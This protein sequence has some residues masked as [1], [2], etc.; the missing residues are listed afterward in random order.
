MKYIVSLI[1]ILLI[2]ACSSH[3]N[4][5]SSS[6]AEKITITKNPCYGY[7][8]EYTFVIQNNKTVL[9]N[10]RGNMKN[11]LK[12]SYSA[13]ITKDKL[14]AIKALDFTSMKDSYGDHGISDLSS[15]NIEVSFSEKE[16]KKIYDY[17]NH[18]TP[19]LEKLY[20]QIDQLIDTLQW[21]KI[22]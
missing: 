19:E 11:N 1:F 22:K 8:P 10:A 20:Q 18:G 15:T 2:N 17:G 13:V 21:V 14:D 3:K 9:L 7:C 12:G 6:A 5:N 4:M 16:P